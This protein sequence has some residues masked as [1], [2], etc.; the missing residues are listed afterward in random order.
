MKNI[1]YITIAIILMGTS[2]KKDDPA[3]ET[4]VNEEELITTLILTYVDQVTSDTKQMV[5]RDLDGDGGNAPVITADTLDAGAMYDLTVELLNESVSPTD[6]IT[7]EVEDEGAEHQ[8]FF[9]VATANLSI[10]YADMDTNGDPI[11]L[12]NTSSAAGASSGS[13]TVTLRHEPDKGAAGVSDGDIT[14]AGGET[15]IEVDFDVVIQ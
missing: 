5:F 14:N 2:C 3:P 11:G 9:E 7:Y 4:P 15:D 8:F 12:V 6:T 10:A 1:T 13:L